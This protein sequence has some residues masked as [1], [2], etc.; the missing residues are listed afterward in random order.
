MYHEQIRAYR[1]ECRN[2]RIFLFEEVTKN[3]SEVL[4]QIFTLLDLRDKDFCPDNLGTA[5]N[6]TGAPRGILSGIVYR[7]VAKETM[8]NVLARW[9]LP[10]KIRHGLKAWLAGKLRA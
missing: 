5:Y 7:L 4:R 10:F 1:E 2:V 8:M 9:F 6:I 3:T